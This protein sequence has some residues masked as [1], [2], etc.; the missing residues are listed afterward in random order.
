MHN[1]HLSDIELGK[2]ILYGIA[3]INMSCAAIW[4]LGFTFN[5]IR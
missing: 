5:L 2:Q 4:L 1:R 3:L